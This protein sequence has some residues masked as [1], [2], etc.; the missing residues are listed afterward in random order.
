MR[1]LALNLVAFLCT[2]AIG[3]AVLL[4]NIGNIT[5]RAFTVVLWLPLFWAATMFY[6]YWDQRPW[7]PLAVMSGV[8]LLCAGYIFMAEPLV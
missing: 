5:D 3:S 2:A 8:T 7:R 1:A 4:T 6:S